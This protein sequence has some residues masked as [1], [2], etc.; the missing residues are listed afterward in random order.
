MYRLLPLG[1]LFLAAL[2]S[3]LVS[4]AQDTAQIIATGR[5]NSPEQRQ[6]P[7]IILISADGFRYDLADKYH[8]E[9]LLGLREGGVTSSAMSPSYP[10]VTFPNHYALVTGLY[11][12]HH[13][14][15]DNI[16]FDAKKNKTYQIR[17]KDVVQDG[18]WYGGTPIWV[19]AEQ[20]HMVTASLFWVGTE[21]AIR[22][23]R[24][25]YYYT[26]NDKIP[27][28]RRIRIVKDWLT[29]PEE[30]RPHLITF[31]LSQVDHA[32]HLY[33]PD[34]KEAEEAVH[35]VDR[36]VGELTRTVDSLHLPVSFVFVSD[37]GM[38]LTDTTHLLGLPAGVDT[39][40]FI[41]RDAETQLHLYAR[42]KHDILPAYSVL[43]ANAQDYDVYLP[44]ETPVRWHYS[45][46]DDRFDRIGDILLVARFPKMFN[47]VHRKPL[48]GM[49]GFDNALADM[50]ASFYAWGPA[51]RQHRKI[52]TFQNV[53]VYPLIAKAL[54][55]TIT[56]Q[57]DGNL[58]TLRDIL[59]NP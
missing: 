42:N 3:P 20:Q 59:A 12:S 41:V 19:L 16:F 51:F 26:F 23:I 31:Y 57:I 50:Q 43:K 21:A 10:S 54:G 58:D 15:V 4:P 11:P 47:T 25:T 34:S 32:E 45:K 8:A 38:A 27:F 44:D 22:G 56:D 48:L 2:S 14:I 29:L 36:C 30:K 53:D 46:S 52:G 5:S 6:K 40:K 7:Y 49:H 55:L 39:T 24:P 28:D 13:G 17:D 9:D 35:L 37:H 18:S 1:S 33:G